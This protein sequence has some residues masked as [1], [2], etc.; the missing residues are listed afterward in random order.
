MAQTDTRTLQQIKRETEQTRR[1]ELLAARGVVQMVSERDLDGR[2]LAVAVDRAM[3][4]PSIRSFPR[5]DTNGAQA[6]V[7]LLRVAS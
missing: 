4:G 7:D 2:T 6:T 1:A 3:A 5:C